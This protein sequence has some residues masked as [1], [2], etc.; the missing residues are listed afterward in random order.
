M[1]DFIEEEEKRMVYNKVS[2]S[3]I[4]TLN[5]ETDTSFIAQPNFASELD[6]LIKSDIN[7]PAFSD[8]Y[9]VDSTFSSGKLNKIIYTAKDE[10]VKTRKLSIQFDSQ[11]NVIL[12]DVRLFNGNPIT[13]NVQH[14]MYRP[15]VGYL[16]KD[17]QYFIGNKDEI[18][19][20]GFF[21]QKRR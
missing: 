11:N 3:K 17:E 2:L 8:K 18:M 7:R 20:E 9:S 15:G 1:I 6:V 4:L 10:K 12:I 13:K 5:G 14:L 21:K 16:I 19:V